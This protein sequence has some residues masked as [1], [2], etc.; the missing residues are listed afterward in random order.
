MK[1]ADLLTHLIVGYSIGTILSWRY[2]KIKA[3]HITAIMFGTILPDLVRIHLLIDPVWVENIMNIPFSWTPI[4][5]LGG[6]LLI[7]WM[8]FLFTQRRHSKIVLILVGIG[9]ATHLLL[10]SFLR[11]ASGHAYAVL[12]PFLGSHPAVPGFYVSPDVWPAL[13]AVPIGILVWIVDSYV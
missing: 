6:V 8:G 10:D 5:T 7:T 11:T 4:H 13:I 9:G 2:E 1:M 12:W 3:P